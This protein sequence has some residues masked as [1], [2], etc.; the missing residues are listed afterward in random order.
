MITIAVPEKSPGF[1]YAKAVNVKDGQWYYWYLYGLRQDIP[2][3]FMVTHK[4]A[5]DGKIM[6]YHHQQC[7]NKSG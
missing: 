2:K 4:Q 3:I 5:L 7:K 6:G 1:R